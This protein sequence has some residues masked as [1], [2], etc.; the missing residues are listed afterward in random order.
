MADKDKEL[1]FEDFRV[2]DTIYKTTINKMYR[3]RKP[4]EVPDMHKLTAFIP[5]TILDIAFKEGDKVKEG[6]IIMYLEAM[7]MKNIIK[8]PMDAVIKKIY[9]KNG[10]IVPKNYL[11]V[12]LK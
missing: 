10:E 1:K 7:K 8:A 4:Y 12:E 3:N 9:V 11:L 5:G 6:D 2:G